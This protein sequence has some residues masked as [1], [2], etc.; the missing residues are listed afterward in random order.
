MQPKPNPLPPSHAPILTLQQE[1]LNDGEFK[2]LCIQAGLPWNP[3]AGYEP[4][5]YN[6][7]AP[8]QVRVLFLMAE[9]GAITRTEIPGPSINNTPWIGDKDLKL[10]ENYWL[11]NLRLLCESFWHEPDTIAMMDHY[12]GGTCSFWMSMPS[13]DQV[14]AIPKPVVSY[15]LDTYLRRL[16]SLFPNAVILAAGG[17]AQQRLSWINIKPIPCSAFTRPEANKERARKSW[18]VA[19][20][21]IAAILSAR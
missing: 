8:E 21:Q 10:Q 15:F 7:P 13:G 2:R 14:K 19:G 17:K 16:L 11:C 20:E 18:R 3:E 1:M 12:L 9:P 4:R 5:W 6:G